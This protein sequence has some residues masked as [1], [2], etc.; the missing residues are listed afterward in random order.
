MLVG[1]GI[2]LLSG[3]YRTLGVTAPVYATKME[4]PYGAQKNFFIGQHASTS[5]RINGSEPS[6]VGHPYAWFWAIKA[7]GLACRNIIEGTGTLTAELYQGKDLSA[8]LSG[9]ATVT[10][11]IALATGMSADLTGVGT[12]TADMVGVV[13]LSGDLSGTGTVTADLGALAGLTADLSG[14]CTITATVASLAHLSADIT[15]TASV[16]FPTA[17]QISQAVMDEIVEAGYDV[18][19]VLALLSSVHLGTTSGFPTSPIFKGLDGSTNR[20]TGT[21]DSNGNRTAVTLN[22]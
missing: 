7:G 9:V 14:S 1:N 18:R 13:Q 11:D 15:V 22:P 2:R 4:A 12:V 19:E 6:G 8:D 3:P 20:V 10:A 21:V 16:D 5:T 17:D